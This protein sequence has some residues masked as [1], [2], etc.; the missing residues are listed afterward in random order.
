MIK[1]IIFD[2]DGLIFDSELFIFTAFEDLY[3]KYELTLHKEKWNQSIGGALAFDPYE[4]ILTKYPNIQ[5][6]ELQKQYEEKYTFYSKG[7]LPREGVLNYLERA[8]EL[9]LHIGLASSSP[10]AWIEEHLNK[11]QIKHYFD[12]ICT[13]DD[14]EQVKPDLELYQRVLDYFKLAPDEAI[15]FE[16]SPNGALAAITAG[17]PCV[18]VPNQV[19]KSLSFDQRVLLRMD[20]KTDLTLDQVIEKA[21]K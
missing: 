11:L 18:I 8:K 10:L 1:A 21:D 6:E 20:S 3:K 4:D 13:S 7:Q 16:D 12:F 19:T 17:I 15:V 2:F 5:K 9:D 14:V